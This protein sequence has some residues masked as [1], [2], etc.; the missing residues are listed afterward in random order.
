LMS[1]SLLL[2]ERMAFVIL[3]QRNCQ[4][5]YI[6]YNLSITTFFLI[7]TCLNFLWVFIITP[8]SLHLIFIE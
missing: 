8:I 5:Y 7:I 2:K 1:S 3:T 6:N 4:V